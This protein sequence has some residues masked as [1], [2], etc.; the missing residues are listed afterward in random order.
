VYI[1]I[2]RKNK[3]F[4]TSN[5]ASKSRGFDF[6]DRSHR[7]LQVNGLF[8][9][10]LSFKALG[11]E[12]LIPGQKDFRS[13]FKLTNAEREAHATFPGSRD[14]SKTKEKQNIHN[15]YTHVKPLHLNTETGPLLPRIERA[16]E[17][18]RGLL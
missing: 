11:D 5:Q 17:H 8:T 4:K 7:E 2:A 12:V 15:N 6:K 1:H 3:C 10:N 16:E 14:L 13:Q 9:L 18:L